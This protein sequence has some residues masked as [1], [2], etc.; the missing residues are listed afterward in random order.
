MQYAYTS[1][2]SVY[3]SSLMNIVPLNP[4]LTTLILG[5]IFWMQMRHSS[6]NSVNIN[7]LLRVI[8][9]LM[10]TSILFHF[11]DLIQRYI[12][13]K[14]GDDDWLLQSF[15]VSWTV[16]DEFKDRQMIQHWN[17]V[18]FSK[19]IHDCVF[20]TLVHFIYWHFC[21]ICFI[22][23]FF[24]HFVNNTKTSRTKFSFVFQTFSN[25]FLF[26][27]MFGSEFEWNREFEE[28][29]SIEN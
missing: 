27:E 19:Q 5:N 11:N 3:F 12:R 16:A 26:C 10:H 29:Y 13:W 23:F 17:D 22:C 8:P 21:R 14:L 7:Q 1:P 6:C 15:E 25:Q 2:S 28:G 24:N 18:N 4:D 9:I 20:W